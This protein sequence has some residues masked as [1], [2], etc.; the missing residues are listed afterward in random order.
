MLATAG[1]KTLTMASMLEKLYQKSKQDTWKALIIVP[2]LGLVNQ[3][4]D[5]FT[6]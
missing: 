6:K 5:D 3:T 2:D 4:F 1:G